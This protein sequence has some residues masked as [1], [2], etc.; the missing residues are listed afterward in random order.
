MID[1]NVVVKNGEAADSYI[2]ELLNKIKTLEKQL[3]ERDEEVR[4]LDCLCAC[5]VDNWEGYDEAR[6]LMRKTR[7]DENT[8]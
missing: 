6:R 8:T 1:P 5:G 4:F 3:D 7:N 2:A